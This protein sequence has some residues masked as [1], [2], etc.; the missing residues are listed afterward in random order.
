MSG[1]PTAGVGL[2]TWVRDLLRGVVE[3]QRMLKLRTARFLHLVSGLLGC[4]SKSKVDEYAPVDG[5][6][7][8]TL[9]VASLDS[10]RKFRLWGAREG[11]A[12]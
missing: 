7:P 6:G 5:Y 3:N 1:Q 2:C 4:W 9:P 8:L 10:R 12:C 11:T